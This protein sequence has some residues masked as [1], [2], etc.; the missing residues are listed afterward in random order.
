MTAGCSGLRGEFDWPGSQ[1]AY[2]ATRF[3]KSKRKSWMKEHGMDKNPTEHG[4]MT[5]TNLT[6][7]S[8]TCQDNTLSSSFA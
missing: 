3:W 4:Q 6:M 8:D 5:V 7:V 2:N 1:S